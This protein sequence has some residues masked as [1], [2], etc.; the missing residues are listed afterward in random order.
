MDIRALRYF[1]AVF[2]HGSLSGAAGACFVAQPSISAAIKQ[3]EQEL[4]CQL[5]QRHSKGVT[6]TEDAHTLFPLARKLTSDMSAIKQ[7]FNQA[8]HK[9]PFRLGLIR[10]LGSQRMGSFL[11]EFIRR[12]DNLEL[13]LV[14]AEQ[15][16]DARIITTTYLA[17]EE[18]FI[19]L[20]RDTYLLAVPASH[21]LALSTRVALSA[22]E[23][24]PFIY[25]SPCEAMEA[26]IYVAREQHIHLDIRARIQTLEYA[27]A[28]VSAGVGC[29]L[30]P[31][32]PHLLQRSDI[33]FLD[34]EDIALSRTIGLAY[35]DNNMPSQA[36]AP[37]I[38]LCESVTSSNSKLDLAEWKQSKN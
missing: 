28:L 26:L 2:E 6:P 30:I 17:E 16:C 22:L 36:L 31:N 11:K 24:L 38:N 9:Q 32:I 18:S 12:A 33:R 4:N 14:D 23:G 5:F 1:I 15:P 34:I 29:A 19:P 27:M 21:P 10:S 25:R 20:W 7:M 13:S 35:A 8:Q 3:L 37:L